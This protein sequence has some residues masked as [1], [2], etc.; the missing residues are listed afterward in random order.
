LK[1]T[2]PKIGKADMIRSM[3]GFTFATAL[4]LNMG[5]Y[6]I[7]LDDDSQSKEIVRLVEIG[8]LEEDYSKDWESRHDPFNGRVYLCYSIGLKYGLLSHQT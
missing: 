5:Y 3:E 2:I 1:N 4:D 6:Y 8:V 7:K